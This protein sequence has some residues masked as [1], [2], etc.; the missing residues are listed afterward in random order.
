MRYYTARKTERT[1]QRCSRTVRQSVRATSLKLKSSSWG[2]RDDSVAK[3]TGCS[4]KEMGFNSHHPQSIWPT[5]NCN[6]RRSDFFFWPPQVSGTHVTHT[7]IEANTH[8]KK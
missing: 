5:T 1:Q 2:W 8:I 4:C 7:Y 3:S 6:F